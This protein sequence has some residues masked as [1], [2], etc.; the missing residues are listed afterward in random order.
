MF[1]GNIEFIFTDVNG[2]NTD[3]ICLLQTE[4]EGLFL[5]TKTYTNNSVRLFN[6]DDI[7]LLT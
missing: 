1:V 6:R 2:L 5:L 4:V 7:T 3:Y